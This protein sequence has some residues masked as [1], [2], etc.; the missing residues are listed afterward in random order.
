MKV[1]ALPTNELERLSA[2]NSYEILDSL[3]ESDFDQLTKIAS[4]I[5]ETPISL[6][7]IVDEDRQ[8]FKSRFGLGAQ[9]TH[10]DYAFCAH[11]ILQP[12]EAFI[13]QDSLKDERFFDNPLVTGDPHV[14]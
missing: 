8:W 3:P 5:C 9:Q 1:A 14:V 2:I 13:V 11:A 4:E 10:R 12:N 6:I 7:S